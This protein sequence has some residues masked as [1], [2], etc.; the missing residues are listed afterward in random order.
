MI[1]TSKST[2]SVAK[3]SATSAP[4]NILG[5]DKRAIVLFDRR[6]RINRQAYSTGIFSGRREDRSLLFH[7]SPSVEHEKPSIPGS[8]VF[9]VMRY[10]LHGSGGWSFPAADNGRIVSRENRCMALNERQVNLPEGFY[11]GM[12]DKQEGELAGHLILELFT[13]FLPTWRSE[14]RSLLLPVSSRSLLFQRPSIPRFDWFY[15]A[16]LLQRPAG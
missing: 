10:F 5:S 3:N 2:S 4:S 12:R 14:K 15:R 8:G 6:F 16:F 11:H 9:L 13:D 7:I 1:F